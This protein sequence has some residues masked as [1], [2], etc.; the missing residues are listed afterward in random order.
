MKSLMTILLVVFFISTIIAQIVVTTPEYPTQS[1]SIIVLFDAAQP[2]AEELL[3]YTGTVYAH[4]GVN[5]NF[6]DWEHVIGDWGNNQ[7]QPA[8]T[9]LGTNLYKLT[10]GFPRQFYGVSNQSEQIQELAIVFRSSDAAKQTRPDIF[11]PL[12]EPGLSI[13]FKNPVVSNNFGD[14]LRSPA[15][16]RKD[17]SV[18]IDVRA[19]E[20]G[21]ELSQL[22]LFIDGSLVTQTSADS[23]IFL[24]SYGNYTP[25]PHD[26][27]AIGLD[28]SGQADSAHIVMFVNPLVI[29]Q[30]PP[31]GI[32]QGINYNSGT[33]VTLMLFAPYKEFI[34]L[35]GDFN[36]W[37]VETNYFLNR[38]EYDS[39]KVVWWITL[40][41]LTIG[42]EYAFQYLVDGEIRIGDPYTKKILDP[43]NDEFIS[44]QTYPNLKPYPQGK[45]AEL[46]SLLQTDQAEYQW[47]NP[48]FQKPDEEK[49]II[50]E[51][52][53]RDF[54]AEHDYQAL[55]D[56]LNYLKQLGVNAIELMPVMEFEGNLSWGYNPSY[57][58]ALDKYYGPADKFKEFI[59]QA[60][61]MGI[62]VIMDMVLNHAF[63][64]S[65]MVRLYWDKVNNR[66]AANSPWFNPIPRHPYNVG[67]DFNHE[68]AATKYYVD[69]VNRQ[70]LSEFNIDGFRFD[71]SKGFTQTYSGN[72]VNLWGQY[73]QSRINILERMADSIW[74]AFPDAYVILEHF[75]V[76]SEETVLSNYGMM[77]WGNMNYEY[78][79]ATMGYSSNLT[80]ATHKSRNWSDM[81]LVS[82]M[83]S[84]DEERLMYKN[85]LYGNSNSNYNIKSFPTAIQ[86]MKLAGAFYL[87]IPG[88]KMIWQ[89]GELGYDYSI[90]YPCGTP[91]C[92]LDPK[93]IRWDY[94]NDGNRKNLYLVWQ[95]LIKLKNYQAFN[96][97][98]YSYSLSDYAKRLT[99]LDSTMNVNIVG[100][101]NISQLNI[102][103]Q[104]PNTGWWYDY[105]SGDSTLI[106]NTQT[107]I[108]LA[109]GEF[110]IYTTV[111]LPTPEIGLVLATD[112]IQNLKLPTEYYLEQN[113]PNPFNP[114]TRIQYAIGSRQFVTLK[115]YDVL[116]NKIATLVNEEKPAGTYEVEFRS[117]SDEGQNLTSGVYFYQ[118]RVGDPETSSHNGQAR[119]DCVDTK[120]MILI[121]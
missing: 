4:T 108:S 77:L 41:N 51:L 64:Q 23:I 102:N 98:D 32:I 113:Y 25:G 26:V 70:W 85:L 43:W 111:K 105:F 13:V 21:T 61:G 3:N 2:G 28:T 97:D 118:L 11:I 10:I 18:L 67:Y 55:K 22:S 1:D 106:T 54:I 35:I 94:F 73:D 45:T 76:N 78:N 101:F 79:E 90:N 91:D 92:R 59:D 66:P 115:V 12:F 99:I 29:N 65:P 27:I 24:F 83:E 86:R 5:T 34:Y 104:F 58:Y 95:A 20:I 46:V 100:N 14:P 96:S 57:H 30:S 82:Y 56:T 120:K 50:Y 110:H 36:D 37:K 47:Q 9:R 74:A 75:A 116:G 53:L 119:Q 80:G 84:H 40:D 112:D 52:L 88:P 89:F 16:V 19:V 69:R 6:G 81:H 38:Y 8:L 17:S 33:S 48:N 109:A 93:P 39:N 103:P 49:L 87:T 7:N 72:D 71:L 15:F 107:E 42:F 63:G 114:T 60:H 68:S 62:A 117:H 31:P 44:S 121:K